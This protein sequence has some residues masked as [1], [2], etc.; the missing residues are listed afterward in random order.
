MVAFWTS[1]KSG[2]GLKIRAL[3]WKSGIGTSTEKKCAPASLVILRNEV[4]IPQVSRM[5][6]N[7][8][9]DQIEAPPQDII[10]I[11]A[12]ERYLNGVLK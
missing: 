7:P 11:Y 2:I 9:K 8:M 12:A 10:A 1:E 5:L 6:R 3:A 4:E